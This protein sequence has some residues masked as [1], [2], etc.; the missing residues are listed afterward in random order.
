MKLTRRG[1]IILGISLGINALLILGLILWGIDHLNWVGDHYCFK[2][3]L[4]CYFPE[5]GAK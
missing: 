5:S 1:E 4:E 3:M 2:S